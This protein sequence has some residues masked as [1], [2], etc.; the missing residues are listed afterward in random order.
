MIKSQALPKGVGFVIAPE[1]EL[2]ITI[3]FYPNGRSSGASFGLKNERGS[4]RMI[5]PEIDINQESI[6]DDRFN[7][8]LQILDEN[9]S[10]EFSKQTSEREITN[11]WN[12]LPDL[13]MTL[14]HL[15]GNTEV[16]KTIERGVIDGKYQYARSAIGRSEALPS[17]H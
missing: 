2:P 3:S 8:I 12:L 6:L 16:N 14:Q 11:L 4:M 13:T 7:T 15:A 10:T 5:K 1:E 17:R 9:L